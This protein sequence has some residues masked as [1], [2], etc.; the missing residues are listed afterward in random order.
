MPEL[1]EPKRVDAFEPHGLSE[2]D[3]APWCELFAAE[4]AASAPGRCPGEFFAVCGEYPEV[5]AQLARFYRRDPA[6]GLPQ[7]GQRSTAGD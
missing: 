1:S 4:K 6:Q 2:G 5:Y 3:L 7:R